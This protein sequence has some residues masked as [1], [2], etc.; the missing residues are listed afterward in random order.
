MAIIVIL[1]I[2]AFF[3]GSWGGVL[4]VAILG[5]GLTFV[6][7]RMGS[8]LVRHDEKRRETAKIKQQTK[9]MTLR[10][11]NQLALQNEL[12]KNCRWLGEMNLE[13]WKKKLP[14]FLSKEYETSF[15]EIVTNFAKQMEEQNILQNDDWFKVYLDEIIKAKDHCMSEF[16]LLSTVTC[17]QMQMTHITPTEQLIREKLKENC[18]RKSDDVPAMLQQEAGGVYGATTYMKRRYGIEESKENKTTTIELNEAL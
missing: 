18:I 7:K 16:Q 2:I 11:K 6:L 8:A 3:A 5:L 1:C 17:P 9:Q 12:D 13:K 14:N 4:T 10:H 15:E